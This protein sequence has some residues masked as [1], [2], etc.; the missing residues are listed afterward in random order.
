[1]ADLR[2]YTISFSGAY[3]NKIITVTENKSGAGNLVF[4]MEQRNVE[5]I[6]HRFFESVEENGVTVPRPA[7]YFKWDGAG[8]VAPTRYS[9]SNR[10]EIVFHMNSGEEIPF[11][12]QH[13]DNSSYNN[14]LM[15]DI[16][17]FISDYYT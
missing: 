2:L 7:Y 15:S 11:E 3:P 10:T 4:K 13:Q 14:G 17:Q 9:I 1:M 12:L 8:D 6:S 16:E 5:R